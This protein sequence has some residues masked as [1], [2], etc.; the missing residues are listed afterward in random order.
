[1][2]PGTDVPLTIT[3]SARQDTPAGTITVTA[4]D[5]MTATPTTAT[6]PALK[7][8]ASSTQTITVGVPRDTS[9]GSYPGSVAVAVG[10]ATY[11]ATFTISVE[12]PNLALGKT[13]TQSSDYKSS[14]GAE[15]AVD[16]NTNGAFS[17]GSVTD[18]KEDAASENQPWW[19][20]D[21]GSSQS[22][23]SV[24]V[25]N[26]TDSCCGKRLG[27]WYVLVSDQPFGSASLSQLLATDGVWSS[28]QTTPPSPSTEV[29]VP[30]GVTGRYLR[31]QLSTTNAP[32]SMAEVQVYP[33][34]TGAATAAG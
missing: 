14:S 25:W 22:L 28:H 33:P 3:V 26:R 18:T 27:D 8:G 2:R 34:R 13:A 11:V 19:Q 15:L 16:G 5:G 1:V 31:I 17:S 9:D 32:L 7:A 4:P 10:K 24:R 23:G 21:L 12:L 29:Q 6:G 30:A 20:V